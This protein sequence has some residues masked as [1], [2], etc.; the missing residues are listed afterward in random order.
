M[1]L[2][3]ILTILMVSVVLGGCMGSGHTTTELER[4]TFT[5]C[6][7]NAIDSSHMTGGLSITTPN[8][9]TKATAECRVIA[10]DA[11]KDY[12]KQE[13]DND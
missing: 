12:V 3:Y 10:Q 11:F 9:W 1:K 2:Q 4:Y 7:L 13:K 8:E 6:M 5:N